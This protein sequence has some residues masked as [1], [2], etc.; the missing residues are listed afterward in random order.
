MK[1]K[2]KGGQI[3]QNRRKGALERLQKQLS[4]DGHPLTHYKIHKEE[5]YEFHVKRIQKEIE[6]LKSR[7]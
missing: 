6:I 2:T 1:P 5:L 4:T 3:L 7:I